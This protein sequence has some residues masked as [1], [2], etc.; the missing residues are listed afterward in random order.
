MSA[1]TSRPRHARGPEKLCLHVVEKV[2]PAV[3]PAATVSGRAPPHWNPVALK[4]WLKRVKEH[5]LLVA[6]SDRGARS[7]GLGAGMILS[8]SLRAAF[9][10]REVMAVRNDLDSK[11]PRIGFIFYRGERWCAISLVLAAATLL[12][13]PSAVATS[14]SAH[15][16]FTTNCPLASGGALHSRD[17]GRGRQERH[18]QLDTAGTAWSAGDSALR[19]PASVR[20]PRD[21]CRR[22][23][24]LDDRRSSVRRHRLGLRGPWPARSDARRRLGSFRLWLRSQATQERSASNLRARPPRQH[25][26]TR[27]AGSGRAHRFGGVG[28]R[29]KGRARPCPREHVGPA[30]VPISRLRLRGAGSQRPRLTR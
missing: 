28:F 12:F 17:L 29:P 20:G 5:R 16:G 1:S 15:S 9:P 30:A 19:R 25:C 2:Q 27:T 13:V 24:A 8:Y 4:S 14:S 23:R 6:V 10:I 7:P 21:L 26:A 11:G 22:L 3:C 18:P